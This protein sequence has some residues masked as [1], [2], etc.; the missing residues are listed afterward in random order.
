MVQYQNYG[1]AP[2]QN[3][4]VTLTLDPKLSYI[5]STA[6]LLSQ[7]GQTLTFDIGTVDIGESGSFSVTFKVDCDATL[8]EILCAES[9]IYPDT[10]CI[11][12]STAKIANSFCLPVVASYDPNDKTAMVDGK[13]QT[14]KILPDKSLEYLIRFQNTGNDTAFT[15]VVKD[16]LS[17]MLEASS[18]VPGAASHPYSFQLRDGNVLEFTFNNI[19]LPDSTTNEPGSHGFVKFAIKQK[20][21]NAIGASLRNK[22][23]IFFDFNDPVITNESALVVSTS[24]G[25]SAPVLQLQA[26]TWPVPAKN[27]VSIQLPENSAGINHW[28]L[29]DVNGRVL[30]IGKTETPIFQIPRLGLPGGVYWCQITLEDGR[31]AFG[32]IVF[33]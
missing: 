21:G 2:A 13:P 30:R 18:V 12:S 23:A 9:H 1:T 6:P 26:Q 5:S 17:A 29:V 4:Y 24:V 22:A 15:I 7:N 33:E 19:L 25:T 28:K 20:A 31:L 11:P 16:T 10:I 14:A 27:L 32:K 8:G 3:A